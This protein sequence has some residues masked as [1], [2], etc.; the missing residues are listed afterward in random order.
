MIDGIA[1]L[2]KVSTLQYFYGGNQGDRGKV[3]V[4]LLPILFT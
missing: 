4:V 1:L 3:V 2:P